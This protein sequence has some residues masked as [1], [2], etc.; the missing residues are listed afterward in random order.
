[1]LNPAN[2]AF[3]A[4]GLVNVNDTPIT[5]CRGFVISRAD[6]METVVSQTADPNEIVT[7]WLMQTRDNGKFRAFART[8]L[9]DRY[10]GR[11]LVGDAK[12]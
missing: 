4:S 1:M 8:V 9:L 10:S 2:A 3:S 5:S 12:P 6:K 11:E 7:R